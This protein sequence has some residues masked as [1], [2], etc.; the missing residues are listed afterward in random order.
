MKKECVSVRGVRINRLGVER[1]IEDERREKCFGNIE[2]Q[3]NTKVQDRMGKGWCVCLCRS[4]S[5]WLW[6]ERWYKDGPTV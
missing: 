3:E 4:V 2:R 5:A 6:P 1:V